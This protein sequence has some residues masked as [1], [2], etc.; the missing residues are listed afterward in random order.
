MSVSCSPKGGAGASG[1]RAFLFSTFA[2]AFVI[3]LFKMLRTHFVSFFLQDNFLVQDLLYQDASAFFSQPCFFL[4]FLTVGQLLG[5]GLVLP[6]CHL[7][8]VSIPSSGI[9][10]E[11]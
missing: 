2:F 3:V 8:A 6:R 10:G 4:S 1:A 9:A 11:Q 7:A 5:S